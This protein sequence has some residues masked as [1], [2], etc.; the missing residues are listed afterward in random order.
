MWPKNVLILQ[1]LYFSMINQKGEKNIKFSKVLPKD[2][3]V[4]AN[5]N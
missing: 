1:K 2:W 4:K 5:F 3:K